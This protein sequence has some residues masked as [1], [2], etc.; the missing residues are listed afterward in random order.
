MLALWR[1]SF[2]I[3]WRQGNAMGV[4][5]DQISDVMQ[6]PVEVKPVRFTANSGMA[7]CISD[8]G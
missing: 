3:E 1:L 8:L 2:C 6:E 5:Q 7:V 4:L